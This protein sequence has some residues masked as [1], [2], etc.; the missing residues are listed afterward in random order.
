MRHTTRAI[1]RTVG[2]LITRACVPISFGILCLTVTAF[3]FHLSKGIQPSSL[4]HF[5]PKLVQ[6]QGINNASSLLLGIDQLASLPN[7]TSRDENNTKSSAYPLEFVHISKTGGTSIE[8]AAANAGIAWGACK[9]KYRSQCRGLRQFSNVEKYKRKKIA[10]KCKCNTQM[11][12]WHCPPNEF[13]SGKNLY[14][15]SKTFAVVRNPY[16]RIISEYFYARDVVE[17]AKH[18]SIDASG[19][20]FLL[21]KF[22]T[23]EHFN[24][25]IA[26]ASYNATHDGSCDHGHCIPMYKYTHNKNGEQIVDHILRLENISVAFPLLMKKYRLPVTGLGHVNVGSRESENKG[27]VSKKLGFE[28]LT[29]ESL[30]MINKWAANDFRYFGYEEIVEK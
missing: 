14:S 19:N 3:I 15:G 1:H 2:T 6:L 24:S 27:E 7:V 13:E 10:W 22:K 28:D 25:W 18:W 9:F 30:A 5:D 4:R 17:R 11:M 8:T 29:S 16:D 21:P 23:S 12:P 26:E 20:Q